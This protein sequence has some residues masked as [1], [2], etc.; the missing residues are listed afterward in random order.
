MMEEDLLPLPREGV[1]VIPI[2]SKIDL[3][4]ALK[5]IGTIMN[6]LTMDIQ[7]WARD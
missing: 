1:S 4:H 6:L 3:L 2:R 5:C 7:I